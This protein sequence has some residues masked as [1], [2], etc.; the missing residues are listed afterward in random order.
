MRP[1]HLF[2]IQQQGQRHIFLYGQNGNQI[3][4]LINQTDLAAAEDSQRRLVQGGNI[5][6]V[7]IHMPIRRR[8]HTA[9]NMQQVAF[10]GAGRPDDGHKLSFRHGKGHIVQRPYLR[11][12]LTVNFR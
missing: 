11:I 9:Q 7:H 6:S 1:V 5:R 3:V 2:V 4:K 12:A 10:A 8:I